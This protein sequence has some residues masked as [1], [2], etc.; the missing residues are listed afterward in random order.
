MDKDVPHTKNKQESGERVVPVSD[1]AAQILS[2]LRE[3]N[4]GKKY[5]LHGTRDSNFAI[6]ANRFN[7]HLRQYCEDAGENAFRVIKYGFTALQSYTKLRCPNILSSIL[8]VMHPYKRHNTTS[9]P[10]TQKE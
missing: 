9:D 2:I 7:G 1:E 3:I 8:L 5:I 10:T 6:S 4:D